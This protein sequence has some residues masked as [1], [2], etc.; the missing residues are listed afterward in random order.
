ML[1]C[2]CPEQLCV[3]VP[4]QA[5]R[6]EDLLHKLLVPWGEGFDDPAHLELYSDGLFDE[7]LD[8]GRLKRKRE[9]PKRVQVRKQCSEDDCS[10]V[11]R[12]ASGLC[13]R[14]G[15]E[16]KQCAEDGCRTG[17]R[18]PSG[19][20]I[21]HGGEKPERPKPKQC[22]KDGCKTGARGSSGFCSRHGGGGAKRCSYQACSSGARGSSGL[23]IYHGGETPKMGKGS[24]TKA[25]EVKEAKATKAKE[26]KEVKEAKATE[27]KEAKEV[28]EAKATE[29]K[30]V[31][32]AKATEAKAT[33]A[34]LPGATRAYLM[35]QGAVPPQQSSLPGVSG[36]AGRAAEA[37]YTRSGDWDASLRAGAA[38]A[39]EAA[40]KARQADTAR[41]ELQAAAA[42][43]DA[44]EVERRL[45]LLKAECGAQAYASIAVDA[46]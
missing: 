14:H 33:E 34:R 27:A 2:V 41:M 4:E 3:C 31:K 32:E 7:L 38:A 30:E 9:R 36:A 5:V 19:F 43:G 29:A 13:S 26:A 15:G 40:V 8:E 6:D 37:E 39:D 21:H 35:A 24:A 45:K 18:G 23:C 16:R 44:A 28:K 1:L 22:S 25:K 11:A 42:R 46:G 12:A 17:A 10:A 20:C